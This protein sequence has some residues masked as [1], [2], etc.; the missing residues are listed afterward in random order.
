[1]NSVRVE[2]LPVVVCLCL[3][4]PSLTAQRQSRVRVVTWDD[5]AAVGPSLEAGGLTAATFSDYVQR[6]RQTN[7]RRVRDGDLD[8][9]IFYLLQSTRFTKLPPIEPALSA[10]ALFAGRDRKT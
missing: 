3:A 9:L 1:M 6:I 2:I 8:H 10:K 4:F 5:V 7:A